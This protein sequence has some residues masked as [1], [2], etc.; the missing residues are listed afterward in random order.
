MVRLYGPR[1]LILLTVV[2]VTGASVA[3][4]SS[5]GSSLRGTSQQVKSMPDR[6]AQMQHHFTQVGLVHEAVIRGDLPGLRDPA[7][8]LA[9]L[10]Q[11]PSVAPAAAQYVLAIQTAAKRAVEARDLASAASATASM[12]LSCGNC[13]RTSGTMPVPATPKRA[14]VGG[15]VGHML[16]HQRAVDEMLEGLFIPSESQW[17]RGAT[18]FSAAPLQRQSLP[19]DRKLTREILLAEERVHQLADRAIKAGDWSDRA[20]IYAQV[21][22][23]CANCHSLHNVVWGP[24]RSPIW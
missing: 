9:D 5:F 16:E 2:T 22:S 19:R 18:R 11:P 20:E 14:E 1:T 17:I 23:T 3:S 6:L 15:L 12:L 21:L 4:V 10:E 24:R 8:R 7:K 13:H